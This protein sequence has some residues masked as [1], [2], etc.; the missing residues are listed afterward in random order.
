MCNL[1][2]L[3]SIVV[4]SLYVTAQALLED[5]DG[6]S[7]F[8]KDIELSFDRLASDVHRNQCIK[9]ALKD[10]LPGC[11]TQGV[12][13]I[14]PRQ[15]KISAV[16]MT[17]CEFQETG[18]AY[19]DVCVAFPT[20]YD[21]AECISELEKT[22]QYWTTFSGYYREVSNIC[23]EESIPFE[24]EQII[25]LY[26]NITLIYKS[27]FEDL[28]KSFD[29]SEERQTVLKA[30][31]DE[32]LSN[33][34][35][36]IKDS[37]QQ[38]KA[39]KEEYKAYSEEVE[40]VLENTLI[41][42][43]DS[44]NAVE[45]SLD[46]LNKHLSFFTSEFQDLLASASQ[47]KEIVETYNSEITE[48]LAAFSDE[49]SRIADSVLGKFKEVESS[50]SLNE[51]SSKELS[52]A[53]HESG[54]LALNLLSQLE[55]NYGVAE[56]YQLAFEENFNE[57]LYNFSCEFEENLER[58]LDA[59]KVKFDEMVNNSV[60]SLE[61]RINYTWGHV[62]SLSQTIDGLVLEVNKASAF[63]VQGL[64]S[65][66]VTH[67]VK[68]ASSVT[69]KIPHF[70]GIISR[71]FENFKVITSSALAVI[72]L[73]L[74]LNVSKV[75]RKILSL[76]FLRISQIIYVLRSVFVAISVMFGISCAL[77]FIRILQFLQKYK[78]IETVLPDHAQK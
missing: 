64:K 66:K 10:L 46:A 9:E 76:K 29:Y 6:G 77:I 38:R 62:E 18:I 32:M 19:P 36:V 78:E 67:I 12:D 49:S 39:M 54:Y 24:K 33:I 16:K 34:L 59:S 47:A 2:L 65:F 13:S 23:Y 55:R 69:S 21:Y 30:K 58:I 74:L 20:D 52:V 8:R 68:V 11:L 17:I 45:F 26:S 53:L 40:I 5:Q 70:T 28:K 1:W 42:I 50:V 60:I 15:R 7:D 48:K 37:N 73:I 41:V 3:L 51:K 27:L 31:F 22:P 57:L 44:Y 63:V 72:V 35:E 56:N 43:Q 25:T 61:N 75:I 71:T 4:L 14:D